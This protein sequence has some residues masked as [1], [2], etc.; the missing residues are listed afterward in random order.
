ML[1][2]APNDI[3]PA[4]PYQSERVMAGNNSKAQGAPWPQLYLLRKKHGAIETL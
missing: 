3:A 4:R 2:L 1:L